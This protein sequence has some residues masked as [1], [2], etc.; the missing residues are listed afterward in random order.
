ML[1]SRWTGMSWSQS[2]SIGVLM[3]TRGLVVLK[4]GYDLGILSDRIFAMLV[5]MAL[6]TTF[7][8]G[9]LLSLVNIRAK[10]TT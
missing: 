4:I 8:T 10:G 3:I 9:P 2:S 6:V 1:M 7:M 5:L